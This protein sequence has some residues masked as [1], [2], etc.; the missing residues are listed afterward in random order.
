M[1]ILEHQY[2]DVDFIKLSKT[3]ANPRARVR[4]L[5]LSR[6]SE[7]ASPKEVAAQFGFNPVTVRALRTAFTERGI[8]SIYDKEGRGRKCRLP[9]SQHEAFKTAIV[10]KQKN[11]G[12]GRL[13]GKGIAQILLDDFG[14]SYCLNGVY[15]L[16][17][18]LDMS[19]ISGRSAHPKR[20][21]QAQE[22]F[23]KLSNADQVSHP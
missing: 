6:L 1:T 2:S 4:L 3:E 10:E 7:G 15:A 11:L 17:K 22:A 23:K 5:M 13:T 21:E 14:V 19:W 8:D 12:G 18:A 20:D 9:Q 16:L